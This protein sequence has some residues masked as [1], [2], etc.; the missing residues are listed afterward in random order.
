MAWWREFFFF[1]YE[2]NFKFSKE[3]MELILVKSHAD[4]SCFTS[5]KELLFLVKFMELLRNLG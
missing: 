1:W 2:V 5:R 3:K 4:V